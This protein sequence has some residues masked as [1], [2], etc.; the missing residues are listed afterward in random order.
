MPIRISWQNIVDFLVLATAIYWLLMWARESG[1]LRILLGIGGILLVASVARRLDLV[2]TAWILNLAVVTAVALLAVA[3][4]AQIR[5]ALKRLDPLRRLM[6]S[7]S[8]ESGSDYQAIGEAAFGLAAARRGA[9]IVLTGNDSLESLVTEGVPLGGAIS[10]DIL[11]AIFRKVS[12]VHDGAVTIEEGRISRVGVFL[13]PTKRDDLSNVY[14][15]RHR[16]ALGLAELSDA[17]IIVVSEERGE[18]SVVQG[19]SLSRISSPA[20]LM[21]RMR[22]FRHPLP[23]PAGRKLRTLLFGN[24][25]LKGLALA[26]ATV[27][28]A[29][30][31]I[32]GASIRTF[33]APIEYQNVPSGLEVTHRSHE[34]L[35]VQLRAASWLFSTLGNYRFVV[36]MDLSGMTLGM[37]SIV[38]Q[39]RHL[40]LP[41]GI[42]F[43]NALPS[44]LTFQLTQ[45]RSSNGS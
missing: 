5:H 18:V 41:P 10:R 36:R 25:G 34:A 26:M 13:P 28:W 11:E 33:S 2:V 24:W 30:I 42:S 29:Q 3:Y 1:V 15:S 16:A 6:G 9:L 27:I 8:L 22:R 31:F 32:A 4:H 12:P 43:E 14:G 45:R 21:E 17:F 39:G 35:A 20:E 40:N 44:V 37:H 38:I 19:P 23:I 7:S